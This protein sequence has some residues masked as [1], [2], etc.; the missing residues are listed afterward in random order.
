ML[1][2]ID[3]KSMIVPVKMTVSAQMSKNDAKAIT[4]D[5]SFECAE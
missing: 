2:K 1:E 3:G 5:V 4:R